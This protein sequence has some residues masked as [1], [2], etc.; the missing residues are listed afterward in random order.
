MIAFNLLIFLQTSLNAHLIDFP[1]GLSVCVSFHP[2]GIHLWTPIS[3]IA[4]S[5]FCCSVAYCGAARLPR[6]LPI[7]G[8]L[9]GHP[10]SVVER[11]RLGPV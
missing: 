11:P 8:A 6:R 3:V 7:R 4:L 9:Y 1:A 5:F 2:Q 10:S